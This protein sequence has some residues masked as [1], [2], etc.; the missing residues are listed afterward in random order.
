MSSSRRFGRVSSNS[1]RHSWLLRETCCPTSPV[2]Q[3]LSSQTQSKPIWANRSKLASGMSS[4][5]AGR[6]RLRDNSF[7]QTRVLIWNS[8][9]YLV[10]ITVLLKGYTKCNTGSY[11]VQGNNKVQNRLNLLFRTLPSLLMATFCSG[12]SLLNKNDR[13]DRIRGFKMILPYFKSAQPLN[14]LMADKVCWPPQ[15]DHFFFR[16]GRFNICHTARMA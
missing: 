11:N 14:I 8:K 2:C 15:R 3:T 9:G 16:H 5:V 7:N 13:T 10:S 12:H 1:F 4:R 6:R